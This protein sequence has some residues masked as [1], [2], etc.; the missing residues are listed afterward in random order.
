MHRLIEPALQSDLNEGSCAFVMMAKAP[1]VGAVKTRL[2]PLLTIAEAATL[3]RCFI[4]DMA[5]NIGELTDDRRHVGVVAFTPAGDEAVFSDLL[6]SRFYLLIQRGTDLGER[7]RQAAEDLFSAGCGAVCLINSDSPTLPR[8]IL[9]DAAAELRPP[10]DRVVLGEAT[11]GG[12]Y[13]IG[14]KKPQAH[15]F[16]QI[17]WSTPRVFAQTV[18]RANEI[19]LD[20]ARLPT[21]YDVDDWASLLLL[22]EE[23]LHPSR[24]ATD[25]QVSGYGAPF[26]SQFLR[27]LAVENRAVGLLLAEALPE[28]RVY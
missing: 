4:R 21:W 1:R 17:D 26:T 11:D 16:H 9:S 5:A 14:L 2:T 12:Y 20:V 22:Y 15:L 25:G 13:L 7:L 24:P 6:P 19:K 23:L 10:G 27:R 8:S 28:L 18:A 3:S